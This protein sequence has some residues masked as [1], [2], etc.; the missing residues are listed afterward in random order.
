MSAFDIIGPIMIGPSSS[1][2]AGA[3]FLGQIARKILGVKPA[4]AEI[5]LHGSFAK[6]AK[7]H[8]TDKALVAGLLGFSANDERIK[9]SFQIAQEEGFNYEI[10][11]V[12]MGEDVHPNSVQFSLWGTGKWAKVAGASLGGGAVEVN[13]VQGR[14]V[15]FNG[16]YATL[17]IFGRNQPGTTNDVTGAFVKNKINIAYLRV[18]RLRHH[19]EAVMVFETDEPIPPRGV[20]AIR[21]LPWVEWV[22]QID[23]IQR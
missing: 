4:R 14:K 18:E 23:K 8:G 5:N 10:N 3:V 17:L 9:N 19:K 21:A 6:T 15:K 16:D 11:S 13:T 20:N 2:T 12:D 1:H 22:C 7:G